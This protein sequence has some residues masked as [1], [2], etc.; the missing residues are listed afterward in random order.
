M[1]YSEVVDIENY[2]YVHAQ[3]FSLIRKYHSAILVTFSGIN[4]SSRDLIGAG[5]EGFEI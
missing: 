1:V 3:E 4:F 5:V 2:F